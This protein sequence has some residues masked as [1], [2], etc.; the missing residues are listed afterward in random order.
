M[1]DIRYSDITD[2]IIRPWRAQSVPAIPYFCDNNKQQRV[3]NNSK[4]GENDLHNYKRRFSG[5][6]TVHWIGTAKSY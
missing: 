1:R 5:V 3:S 2:R 4:Y 6:A